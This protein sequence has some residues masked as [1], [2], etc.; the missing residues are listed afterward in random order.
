MRGSES[1]TEPTTAPVDRP[2]I[3]RVERP[4]ANTTAGTQQARITAGVLDGLVHN[5]EPRE[6]HRRDVRVRELPPNE[7]GDL[8]MR[9][10]ESAPL[11]VGTNILRDA[12]GIRVQD[13]LEHP[14]FGGDFVCGN[15]VGTP[16]DVLC[17]FCGVR[18]PLDPLG[19]GG[20]VGGHREGD[21]TVLLA[22]DGGRGHGLRRG[23][24]DERQLSA[25][26]A[27]GSLNAAEL[28]QKGLH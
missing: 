6:A 15:E 11:G 5:D 8:R 26:E 9:G 27:S 22:P 1:E 19:T 14:Y 20:S 7:A 24:L 25:Q 18:E 4:A 3:A 12:V 2:V 28:V 10:G 21:H 16:Q 13:A 23:Y 17:P